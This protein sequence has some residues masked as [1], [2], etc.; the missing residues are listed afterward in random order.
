M[1]NTWLTRYSE[2][3]AGSNPKLPNASTATLLGAYCER[4][5][6][7]YVSR[8]WA[9]PWVCVNCQRAPLALH[10]LPIGFGVVT[11]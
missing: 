4:C 3:L 6:N 10:D 7:A 8:I 5:G 9:R 2:G 1:T 11:S